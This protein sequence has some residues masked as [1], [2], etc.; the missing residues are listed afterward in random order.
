MP[1][2]VKMSEKKIRK[3]FAGYRVN[4]NGKLMAWNTMRNILKKLKKERITNA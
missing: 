1:D 4:Y 2:W 3:A